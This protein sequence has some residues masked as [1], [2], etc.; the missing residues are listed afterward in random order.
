VELWEETESEVKDNQT[1]G[2][3]WDSVEPGTGKNVARG[4]T[5][6]GVKPGRGRNMGRGHESICRKNLQPSPICR[7][8]D[9]AGPSVL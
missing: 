7:H 5:W 4:I 9:P 3:V 2:R 8:P 1:G 6:E